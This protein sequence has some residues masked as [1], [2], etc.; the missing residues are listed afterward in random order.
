MLHYSPSPLT[1]TKADGDEG[2][3]NWS[4]PNIA[5]YCATPQV[6]LLTDL[7]KP[8]SLHPCYAFGMS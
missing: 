4:F 1:S 5:H 3:C 2:F 6:R 8:H 7:E